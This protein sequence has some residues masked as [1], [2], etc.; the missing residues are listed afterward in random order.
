MKVYD[1]VVIGS[2]V[3]LTVT[4]Q[5]INA[6]MEVALVEE[7]KFGGTCLTRGC[8]PSKVLIH[9]A[10]LI[11]EAEHAKRVGLHFKLDKVDWKHISERMWQEIDESKDIEK[12]IGNAPNLTAYKGIGEFTGDMEM[13]VKLNKTME[14]T[15][16][17]KGEKI[18]IASG[19]RTSIPPIDGIDKVGYV[20]SRSFFGEKFPDEPWNNLII[21]GGG[22]IAAEFAHLFSAFGTK[23]HVV[24]ML[25]RL[26]SQE[27]PELSALL[28]RHFRKYM[29][30]H[31]DKKAIL[32]EKHGSEKK[33]VVEDL[34]DGSRSEIIA[35]EIFIAAGRRSNSD[36]LKP[37]KTGIETDERGWIVTNRYM[38]TTRDG[39]WCVG[40]AN[41]KYQ[42]RHTANYETEIAI[43]NIFNPGEKTAIDYTATPW[44]IFTYPQI[45]HVGMTE[46]EAIDAGHEI[47]VAKKR[48]GEV[49]KGFAMGY[50]RED[51]LAGFVKLVIDKS[52]KLLGAHV[53][54]SNAALLVQQATY[55]MNSGFECVLQDEQSGKAQLVSSRACPDAGSIMPI[56]ESQV[57]HPSLNEVL[58]WAL[59]SM[60]P[61]N[62]KG[63]QHHREH[64]HQ[65]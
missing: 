25:P 64:T 8:I 40:D 41:G 22:I 29:T 54:G 63:R 47:Y 32:A 35:D 9:P 45:G 48:Y 19:A 15:A 37:G 4:S 58:G 3:G 7:G 26:V 55:I 34:N 53:I 57:I 46:Q 2:G 33:L 13:K 5:A 11:R 49:A 51:E 59:G 30:V 39:I 31:L 38:E 17:F 42:F 20:T 65:H 61:V 43:R 56:A 1:M 50:E 21:V 6:G 27:D 44:V 14:F 12:G 23:V 28:E 52:R 36:W 10:D 18:V 24:E 60:K 16:P 62:I